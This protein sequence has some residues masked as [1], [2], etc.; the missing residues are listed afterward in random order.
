M[1]H[2]RKMHT[3]SSKAKARFDTLRAA[4]LAADRARRDELITQSVKYGT[5][6]EA[7]SWASKSEKTKLEKLDKKR[8]KI[9]DK[10]IDLIV[11][12]SPRGEMWMSGVP[13]YWLHEKLSWD[14]LVRPKGEPLTISPP[15]SYGW[16][17]AEVRRHLES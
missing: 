6:R 3:G 16:T 2:K 17:D 12:E 10:I 14:D 5:E 11:K 4:Y 9:G 15:A 13:S 7:R 1:P 8:D